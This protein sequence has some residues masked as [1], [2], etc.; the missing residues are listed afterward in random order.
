MVSSRSAM[1]LEAAASADRAPSNVRVG[2][3][4]KRKTAKEVSVGMK[5]SEKM[6]R[7]VIVARGGEPAAI[8][9]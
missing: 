7:P 3:F 9:S 6:G 4:A 8:R 1:A 2:R 5:V